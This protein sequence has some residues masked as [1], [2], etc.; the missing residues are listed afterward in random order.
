MTRQSFATEVTEHTEKKS[1]FGDKF[2]YVIASDSVAIVLIS[3][4]GWGFRA[5][6]HTDI[7]KNSVAYS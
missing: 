5:A 6:A 4:V 3:R 1:G 7:P 2:F